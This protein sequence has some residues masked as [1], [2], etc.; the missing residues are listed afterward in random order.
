M[1]GVA[2]DDRQI[3]LQQPNLTLNQRFGLHPPPS[4]IDRANRLCGNALAVIGIGILSE[5]ESS[6]VPMSYLPRHQ[7]SCGRGTIRGRGVTASTWRRMIP[8]AISNLANTT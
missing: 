5:W 7:V 2:S 1:A 6:S 4:C 3:Q 8:H